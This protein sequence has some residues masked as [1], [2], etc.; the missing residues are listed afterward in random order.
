[1][2]SDNA[3]AWNVLSDQTLAAKAGSRLADEA[4][5]R[6]NGF[7]P[8][9]TGAPVRLFPEKNEPD[10]VRVTLFR[11]HAAWCPHCQKVWLHLE[12]KK[13]PHRCKRMPLNACGD[14][15]AWFTRK[16]DR[17]KLPVMELDGDLCVES[18]EIIRLLE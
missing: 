16:V 6:E 4:T 5:Q 15:D 8:P 2:L 9:H 11:D 3:P 7:G 17:G 10:A 12:L 14:K 13:I 18:L 1:M